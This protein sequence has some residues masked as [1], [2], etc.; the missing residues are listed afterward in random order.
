MTG[1]RILE[2]C[3]IRS[4]QTIQQGNEPK[5]PIVHHGYT[6]ISMMPNLYDHASLDE[7]KIEIISLIA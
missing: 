1:L 5:E 2:F 4:Y 7:V 3:V 6:N